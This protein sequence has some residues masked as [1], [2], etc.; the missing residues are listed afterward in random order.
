RGCPPECPEA[1]P[2]RAHR[3]VGPPPQGLLL[4]GDI[5]LTLDGLP[6]RRPSLAASYGK[7]AL[8]REEIRF[9]V[10]RGGRV[11][12]VIV[13]P[14]RLTLW[15][16]VRFL[17]VPLA[18]MVAAPLVAFALAWRRPDLGTAWVF[19]W[20]AVLQAVSDRKSTRL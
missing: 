13:P 15:N 4:P 6:V 18:A 8:P 10:R 16:R 5:L 3:V 17:V 12:D 11:L 9:E 1:A 2:P 14:A 20:F 7:S 19:F